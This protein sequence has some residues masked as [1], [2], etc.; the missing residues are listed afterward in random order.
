[1]QLQRTLLF[2][3]NFV[4][5]DSIQGYESIEKCLTIRVNDNVNV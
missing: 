2:S 3:H 5:K 4:Y 1:M